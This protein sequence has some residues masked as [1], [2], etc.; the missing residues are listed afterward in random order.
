M[1]L[2]KKTYK[3]TLQKDYVCIT[4]IRTDPIKTLYID[5]ENGVLVVKK[6]YS[7]DGVT[8]MPVQLKSMIRASLVHDAFYQLLRKGRLQY[9]DKDKADLLFKN[10]CVEDGLNKYLAYLAYLALKHFGDYAAKITDDK[11]AIIAP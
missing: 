9:A 8:G 7:W 10:M 5:L 1:I 4:D 3:N 2:Y 6:H 11:K